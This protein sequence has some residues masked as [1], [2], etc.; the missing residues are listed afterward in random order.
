VI[1]ASGTAGR[2]YSATRIAPLT[3]PATESAP[4]ASKLPALGL[5]TDVW[6][7]YSRHWKL[8]APLA[9]VALLPQAIGDAVGVSVDT[10]DLDA[11]RAA[12]AGLSAAGLVATNL[13]GEALYAGVITALV[14]EWRHGVERVSLGRLARSLPYGRLI[15]ADLL[16]ASGTALGLV[17]LIVPGVV[18]ATY[19]LLTTVVIELEGAGVRGAMRRSTDLVRGSFWRVL[20]IAVLML[21]GTETLSALLE[22]PFH[23]F[24]I[25]IGAN[26]AAEAL[27]EPFQGVATVLIA[28]G[29]MELRGEN[30]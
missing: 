15:A 25:E 18:F 23:G 10:D 7:V 13:G 22:A 17:L 2:P 9:M 6:R 21:A 19:T 24:A 28:L 27:L 16:I 12:L 14:V 3:A 4:T 8:L 20:A 26:L 30:P 11:G 1:S 5:L 29:L